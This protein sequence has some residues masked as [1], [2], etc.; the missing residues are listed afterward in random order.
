MWIKIKGKRINLKN[1]TEYRMNLNKRTGQWFL[2]FSYVGEN[3]ESG[4][5]FTRVTKEEGRELVKK[6]DALLGVREL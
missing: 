5:W 4:F 6:I 1:V 2:K 3:E